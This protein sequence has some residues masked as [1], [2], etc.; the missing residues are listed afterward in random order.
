MDLE[1]EEGGWRRE[2]AEEVRE[3]RAGRAKACRRRRAATSSCTQGTWKEG[4]REA[5]GEGGWRKGEGD[6][7]EEGGKEWYSVGYISTSACKTRR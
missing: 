3:A 6:R 4:A 5:A 7:E 2:V 1:G